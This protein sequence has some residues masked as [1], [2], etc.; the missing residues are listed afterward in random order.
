MNSTEWSHTTKRL[1]VVGLILLFLLALYLFRILLPPLAIAMVLAYVLKPL[2]DFI[3][4]RA[5]L[6]RLLAVFLVFLMLLVILSIIPATVVPYLVD[7]VT[8]LNLDLQQLANDLVAFLSRPM[9]VLG[10]TF[11]LQD[12]VGDVQGLSQGMLRPFA[13]GTVTLIFNVAS[14]LLWVLSIL[15]ISFYLVKDADRLRAC[16]DSLAP[17]GY[18]QELRRLR[19]E[20]GLVWKSFF[21]GQVVLGM[22]IGLAVWIAMTAV[23]LPNAG[24]MGFLAGVLEVVPTFGPVFATIPALFIALFRGSTYLPLSNFWFAVLVVGLYALIQQVENAYLVPRIMG[25]RLQLHPLVVFIGVLAGGVLAGALGVLL[26]APVI[27]TG[28]VLLGYVY[29]RL[30]DRDPFPPARDVR[31]LYAGEID[32]ILF[33]LDGTLVETD[34]EAVEALARRLRPVRWLLPRRDPLRAAR[35]LLM[36]LET[37]VS[38]L[39]G[40]LDRLGLDDK[41]F[42]LGQRLQRLRG[43]RATPDF[44]P[45]EGVIEMLR[46]LNRRYLLAII[47]TRSHRE[48]QAFLEQQALTDVVRVITGRDDTWRLKPHPS[49]VLHTAQRLGVAVERCLMVGDTTVD[50]EAAR[51][52]GAWSVGVLCGFGQRDELER[53]GADLILDTTAD[54]QDWV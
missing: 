48:A 20:I 32:A 12:V 34:D 28:R 33:D 5:R 47:T 31:E 44:R 39:V 52:A 50:I 24:L 45:V 38:R 18:A 17:P 36:A 35:R 41:L 51:A 25:R 26:A 37:P 27:A 23:G 19:Q 21:R 49:P 29:A 14:S 2:A 16:L 46:D 8:R 42:G 6:P 15:V 22:I 13:T 54:L 53:A 4:R 1:V 40:L 10:F 11:N 30:L 3:E 7:Q 9:Q 43:V